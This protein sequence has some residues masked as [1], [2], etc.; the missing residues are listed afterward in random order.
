MSRIIGDKERA[1]LD[2]L[3]KDRYE[4]DKAHEA[5]YAMPGWFPKP[6]PKRM[7]IERVVE[8]KVS[9]G[10]KVSYRGVYVDD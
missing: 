2:K 5:T 6:E 1:K 10:Q 9:S 8:R 7:K 4:R 3:R